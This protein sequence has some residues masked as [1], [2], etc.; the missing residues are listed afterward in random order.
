MQKNTIAKYAVSVEPDL[1]TG[2]CSMYM[3]CKLQQTIKVHNNNVNEDYFLTSEQS[4]R[5]EQEVPLDS[6]DPKPQCTE[7]LQD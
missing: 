2:T 4:E 7:I 3:H 5:S 1:S 6:I